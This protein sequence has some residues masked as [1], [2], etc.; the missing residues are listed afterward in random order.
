MAVGPENLRH[1][2]GFLLHTGNKCQKWF[3]S[4]DTHDSLREKPR[5][6]CARH[7]QRD[8]WLTGGVKGHTDPTLPAE[9][10]P[11]SQSVA[12]L[13][14]WI[15]TILL[16]LNC[17]MRL[18]GQLA[19]CYRLSSVRVLIRMWA[20]A[21][22]TQTQPH[23]W[24]VGGALWSP[25]SVA[26]DGVWGESTSSVQRLWGYFEKGLWRA[27]SH[28]VLR[29]NPNPYETR[30]APPPPRSAVYSKYWTS[31]TICCVFSCSFSS[32]MWL[33]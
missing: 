24:G 7:L 14:G 26:W 2:D 15:S 8:M 31:V 17:R 16:T 28:G 30:A 23:H 5:K 25:H 6:S 29:A 27:H 13:R 32:N 1:S 21:Q 11:T 9:F 12:W 18:T 4:R 19:E 3:H 22:S 33:H 20:F 10:V